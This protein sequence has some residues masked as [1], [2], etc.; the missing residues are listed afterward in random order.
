M[1]LLV[2]NLHHIYPLNFL[3]GIDSHP[4][5]ADPNSLPGGACLALD[6]GIVSREGE[7]A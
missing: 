7:Y 6:A 2:H 5:G 4:K 1:R 3:K